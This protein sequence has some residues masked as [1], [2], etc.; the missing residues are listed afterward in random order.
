MNNSKKVIVI[1][2]DGVNWQLINKLIDGGF[3]PNIKKIKENGSFSSLRTTLPPVTAP[4]WTSFATGANPGQHGCFE[5][6]TP[7]NDLDDYAPISS[8]SIKVKTFYEQLDEIGKKCILV[9]LPV[10]FPPK[11]SEIVI[12]SLLT[13]GDDFVFPKKLI[14]EIPE[15]TKYKLAPEG[16]KERKLKEHIHEIRDIEQ[17]RFKCAQKLFKNKPWDFFFVLFSGTDWIQHTKYHDLIN[18]DLKKNQSVINIYQDIDS[19]LGWFADNLPAN[20]NLLVMSDHGFSDLKGVFFLNEWLA[21]ENYLQFKSKNKKHI[22]FG[23]I[24][25]SRDKS[26]KK[27]LNLNLSGL[28]SFMWKYPTIFKFA[29]KIYDKIKKILPIYV[30]QDIGIDTL[31]SSVY[32][33]SNLIYLNRK[34]RF[35]NGIIDNDNEY[36]KI[37]QEIIDKLTKIKG[38]DNKDR[39]FDVVADSQK[40]YSGRQ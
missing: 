1:G 29:K 24:S 17:T 34:G 33:L 25:E 13:R 31:N 15:F 26:A 28:T 37:K 27:A 10:S 8:N 23:K 36:K 21:K 30:D 35:S 20:T 11:L 4:A 19:Y 3:L 12:T 5:F 18:Q 32:S 39:V 7:E 6:V 2:L 40:I 14:D 22:D 38:P 16:K 9:N